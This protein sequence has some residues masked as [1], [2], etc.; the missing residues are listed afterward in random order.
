MAEVTGYYKDNLL[1]SLKSYISNKATSMSCKDI[2]D[3]DLK[4]VGIS[5]VGKY[6]Y[7]RYGFPFC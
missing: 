1:K 7:C 2:M 3:P 6:C 5:I 4:D